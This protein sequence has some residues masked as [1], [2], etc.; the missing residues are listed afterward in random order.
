MKYAHLDK[1]NMVIGWYDDN[2][3]KNI[4]SPN[5]K[6]D[7]KVYSKAKDITS[8]CFYENGSFIYKD[9]RT[10]EDI[11]KERI[12]SIKAKCGEIIKNK[13]SIEWQLNH[14]RVDSAYISEYSWIDNIRN[15]SNKSE[16]DGTTLENIDWGF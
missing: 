10:D 13:Y 9:S 16:A 6:V 15:I 11:E 4:P 14:P 7:E 1:D 8:N 3:H 2:H 5:I 12:F